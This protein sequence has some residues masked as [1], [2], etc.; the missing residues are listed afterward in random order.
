MAI[1]HVTL[2]CER[3]WC[4]DQQDWCFVI[5]VS[6]SLYSSLSSYDFISECIF[7][8]QIFFSFFVHPITVSASNYWVCTPYGHSFLIDPNLARTFFSHN[9]IYSLV[10]THFS[11]Y[12]NC[13]IYHFLGIFYLCVITNDRSIR[14]YYVWN[15]LTKWLKMSIPAVLSKY[16]NYNL[17]LF[18]QIFPPFLYTHI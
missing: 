14:K 10:C 11:V 7:L 12:T 3:Y 1:A 8:I 2:V 13:W 16:F 6:F 15:N 5:F 17:F 9:F 4:V 18:F